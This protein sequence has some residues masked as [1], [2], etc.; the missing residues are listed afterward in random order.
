MLREYDIIT[1]Q[2]LQPKC[3][4]IRGGYTAFT[5]QW[6]VCNGQFA[7]DSFNGQFQWISKISQIDG[8]KFNL[9]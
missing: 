1:K 2:R 3:C 8:S 5:M 9:M 4:S 6:T 7:M